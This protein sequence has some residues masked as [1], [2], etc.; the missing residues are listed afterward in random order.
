MEANTLI[1]LVSQGENES[2]D[3]KLKLH[4]DSAEQKAEFVKDIISLANSADEFGYLIIG[5]DKNSNYIG[6]DSLEEERIQQ[7]V[8][9]YIYPNVIVR[10]NKV[11]VNKSLLGVIEVQGIEKPHR[12][13]KSIDRLSVNEVF[14]RHGSTI[15]K[16]SPDEMFRM[17]ERQTEVQREVHQLMQ[18]GE[19]HLKIGNIEQAIKA[20]TKAIEISPS[21]EKL[22]TRAKTYRMNYESSTDDYLDI[23]IGNLAFKDLSDASLLNN[24]GIIENK[25]RLERLELL[26]VCP[27]EEKIWEED[28]SW[29][30][31]NLKGIDLGK[32]L[33]YTVRRM[34]FCSIYTSEGWNNLKA[35]ELLEEATSLGYSDS[36]IFY[37]MAD[38]HKQD[39]NYGLA[40][41]CINNAIESYVTPKKLLR[42]YLNL[43]IDIQ[44][45]TRDYH[46]ALI[47]LKESQE[48]YSKASSLYVWDSLI[49]LK[50]DIYYRI[51]LLKRREKDGKIRVFQHILQLLIL[52]DGLPM[53]IV[54]H[55]GT[56]TERK[57]LGGAKI[58]ERFP[59]IASELKNI[60][61]NKYWQAAKNG[62]GF[63]VDISTVEQETD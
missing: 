52:Q 49:K 41:K 58:D 16:A 43:R 36:Q 29:A 22:L 18:A 56:G 34:N 25:I 51:C 15:A 9:T 33:F 5:V 44:I 35:M 14:V 37:Y 19:N 60:V 26:S 8:H 57:V 11:E 61:G 45:R 30:F 54:F 20:Y 48:V 3:F 24:S 62:D 1:S 17:R 59:D 12:V 23:E 42:D 7:I 38:I 13:I 4:F 31:T 40:L 28:V 10:C 27:I 6:I 50:E 32:I 21:A 55:D 39:D 63:K 46:Q 47:D 53:K 2:V